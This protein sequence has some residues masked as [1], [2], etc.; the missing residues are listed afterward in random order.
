MADADYGYVG[1]GKD[2]I[3]LY[4]GQEVVERSVPAKDAV[5][6]LID[7]IKD[8]GDWVEVESVEVFD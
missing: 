3:T 1:S 4:K 2:K 7:I 5:N 8:G 6:K